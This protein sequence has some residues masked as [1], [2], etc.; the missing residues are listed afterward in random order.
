M[1]KPKKFKKPKL[2]KAVKRPFR[3][4]KSPEEKVSD[5][6]SNVPRITNDTVTD[7][8]EEVLSSARRYIYPL[9]H[10]KHRIVRISIVIFAIVIIGFFTYCGL[11]LYKFQNT[12]GFL[13]NVTRIIPFPVAKAGDKW[14][15]YEAYLFELRRNMHYYRDQQQTD[16]ASKEGQEQLVRLK[17]QA[18][19][20]VIRDAYVKQ[21]AGRHDVKVTDQAVN[22]Q[23]DL[24]RNQ[25][26]L[27]GNN[28]AFQS[29]LKDFWG[30]SEADFK[31]ALKQQML[32]QAVVAEL[33][34]TTQTKAEAA[35]RQLRGGADFANLAGQLSE[36][37]ATKANGGQYPEPVKPN[38]P[39]VPPILTAELFRL[40]LN[41]VSGIINSGYTLE[42]VKISERSEA[43]VRAAHLQFNFRDAEVF[44]K[45]LRDQNSS[46]QYIKL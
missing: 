44:I 43:G 22:Q 41:Q 27:G 16:F 42:I 23:L 12:G 40:P 26:R 36:D 45:P 5:A 13:Y 11:S 1:K 6:L 30:W 24:A 8:R 14:V 32:Q 9:Q 33:D 35:L 3:R 25:N 37:L 29:V 34:T 46:S 4:G 10:S 15:S 31:R 39:D 20:K 21:L 28:R 7:H 2:P 17:Q 19:D 18:M 38:E